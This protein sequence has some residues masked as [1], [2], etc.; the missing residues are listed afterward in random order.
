MSDDGK[1]P[2]AIVA[3]LMREGRSQ[4]DVL[5]QLRANGGSVVDSIKALMDGAGL[6]LAAAK[7][8]V[9]FSPAWAD[10]REQ[11]EAFHDAIEEI[12]NGDGT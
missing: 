3:R 8:A 1:E 4:D 9:H 5:A 2:A 11:N 7:Q 6:S 10:Q 12:L